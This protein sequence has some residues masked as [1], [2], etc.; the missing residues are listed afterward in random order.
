MGNC[1]TVIVGN[2][3][4][5]KERRRKDKENNNTSKSSLPE[6]VIGI[7]E[8]AHKNGCKDGILLLSS[9]YVYGVSLFSCLEKK[10][11]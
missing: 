1:V 9:Q 2:H 7:L 3:A 4:T 11:N 10:I 5:E 6:K 8:D